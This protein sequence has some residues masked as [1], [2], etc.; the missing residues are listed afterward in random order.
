MSYGNIYLVKDTVMSNEVF[1]VVNVI[2]IWLRL[3]DVRF[4]KN[5]L[6]IDDDIQFKF[7]QI[8]REP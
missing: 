2:V 6:F 8:G 3:I 1:Q 7:K 4:V 5:N